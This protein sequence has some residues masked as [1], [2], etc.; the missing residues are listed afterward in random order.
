MPRMVPAT[1]APMVNV[2]EFSGLLL[3]DGRFHC[4]RQPEI[5]NLYEAFGCDLDVGGLQVPVDDV[6]LV[7]RF[8]AI[9]E[10]LN[11][12]Q[13]ILEVHG[14]AQILALD[15]LH[16][17]IIRP[18]VVEMADVG[19]VERGNGTGF[20]GKPLGEL[21]VGNFDRDI[22]IQT[23]IVGAI[24]LA[25]ATLADERED[26]VGAEFVACRERHMSDAA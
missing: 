1:V 16:D 20:T 24:H 21:G 19:V 8:D 10:L 25:H 15:I 7:R 13:S 6:L 22:P 26:L 3:S 18:D 11:D 4:F 9:D 2:G 14:T 23:G 5:Q 12:R 17:Q